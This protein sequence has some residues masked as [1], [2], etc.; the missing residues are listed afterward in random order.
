MFGL[1]KKKVH[2]C[3]VCGIE[4]NTQRLHRL[5]TTN[6]GEFDRTEKRFCMHHLRDKLELELQNFDG[7]L[8]AFTP[9][10]GWN[11]Y[12]YTIFNGAKYF[13]LGKKEVRDLQSI[14]L[15]LEDKCDSCGEK[16]H[17]LVYDAV[18]TFNES[19]WGNSPK[20]SFCAK[21]FTKHILDIVERGDW[22]LDE[23]NIPY[24]EEGV[25]MQGEY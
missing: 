10:Q 23:I 6:R 24:G 13:G 2:T 11:S 15:N 19:D 12:S 16:A 7:K 20:Y 8:V 5:D 25:Y 9:K 4:S 17:M 3:Q 21:H 1:L 14:M 18:Y 22:T